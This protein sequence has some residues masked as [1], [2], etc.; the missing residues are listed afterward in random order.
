MYI[1]FEQCAVRA[2]EREVGRVGGK[3]SIQTLKEMAF[4]TIIYT[5]I[6]KTYG[7]M[8]VVLEYVY[9]WKTLFEAQN[10]SNEN[11]D[12]QKNTKKTQKKKGKKHCCRFTLN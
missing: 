3:S 2:R 12:K 7:N 8:C 6:H 1:H 4:E 10:N 5:Y 11:G 9:V